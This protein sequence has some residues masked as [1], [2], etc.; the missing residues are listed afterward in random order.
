MRLSDPSHGVPDTELAT[1]DLDGNTLD[2]YKSFWERAAQVDAK[3]AIADQT[4]DNEFETSGVPERDAL[5]PLIAATDRVLEI[6][7]GIGRVMQ[8]L[9][10]L[11]AEVHGVDISAEMAAAGTERLA[12]LT[13]V[14]FHV[15]NGYDL[16]EFDD[17]YFDLV[18]STIALQHMP[19]TTAFNY[20]VEAHRVLRPEG[21]LW[22]YVPNLL[23]EQQFLAF[24]HFAQPHF[25]HHPY[26]MHFFTPTEAAAL[27]V[28][29]GFG[30]TA[31]TGEMVV[32]ATRATS[33]FVGPE[34][35]AFLHE[36][37]AVLAPYVL[38]PEGDGFADRVR[39]VVERVRVRVGRASSARPVP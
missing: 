5:A 7:C 34:V 16:G 33:P 17:E 9:S 36:P 39:R 25:V 2:D 21:T 18:Y 37:G 19:K 8:H 10:P 1:V 4:G 22:L 23:D 38:E 6:G 20:L 24:N 14:T 32:T 12:H 35:K 30:V 15:G 11:C 26:P 3:R 29:A 31:M 13:N 27:L 28:R